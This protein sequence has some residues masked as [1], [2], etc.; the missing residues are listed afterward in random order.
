M[1]SLG[2]KDSIR[3]R[4]P[5]RK[6]AMKLDGKTQAAFE[7]MIDDSIVERYD[8][9]LDRLGEGRHG[10]ICYR[11]LDPDYVGRVLVEL[12]GD[13]LTPE[14]INAAFDRLMEEHDEWPHGYCE[15]D[16]DERP[17]SSYGPE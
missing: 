17:L 16:E 7:T 14:A 1:L 9:N 2:G 15:D 12:W 6:T 10:E 13:R 5:R 11:P 3:V 8:G 4:P